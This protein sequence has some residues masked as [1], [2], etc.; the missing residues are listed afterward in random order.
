[1]KSSNS[2]FR[3]SQRGQSA[4][5][6]G[7]TLIELLVVIA[8][9]AILAAMLLPALSKAKTKATGIA[10]M[11]NGKQL[12][13]AWLMYSHDNNDRL[14]VGFVPGWLD[15]G[16]RQD[17]TNY[18]YLR[19][20]Q[21]SSL[22]NYTAKAKNLY[23]CPADTFLSNPQKKQGWSERVRSISIN[24]VMGDGGQYTDWYSPATHKIYV[25]FSDMIKLPPSK[26]W[27]FVDQ[28]PDSIND[29]YV[30]VHMTPSPW[31]DAPASYHNNACGFSFADG[32][33]EIHKWRTSVMIKPVTYIVGD[34]ATADLNNVDF[35]WFWQRTTEPT[36]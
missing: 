12:T 4:W 13:L 26:A 18:L 1:M 10:C 3:R 6:K 5:R 31:F 19:D 7:F 36:Q 11:N 14:L 16:L 21:Y 9:I 29:S 27:V 20:A 35:Q 32:H 34:F 17:N 30:V 15:W 33:S 2:D 25:K 8:I 24:A 22:A 23:K 28:H